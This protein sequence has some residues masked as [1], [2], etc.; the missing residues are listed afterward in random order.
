MIDGKPEV[1]PF[2]VDLQEDLIQV[3]P[4]AVRSH[5]LNLAQYA[6]TGGWFERTAALRLGVYDLKAFV[7]YKW[8]RV[9]ATTDA[10]ESSFAITPALREDVRVFLARDKPQDNRQLAIVRHQHHLIDPRTDDLRCFG[11]F[12]LD[13]QAVVQRGEAPMVDLSHV[14]MQERRRLFRIRELPLQ[15]GPA[16]IHGITYSFTKQSASKLQLKTCADRHVF[17]TLARP[18]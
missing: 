13:V 7:R 5:A 16:P 8:L 12:V 1:V 17:T 10:Y 18:S 14:R 15:L 2:A 4:P 6:S 3:P 11:I 9:P